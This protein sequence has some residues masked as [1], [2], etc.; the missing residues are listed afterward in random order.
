MRRKRARQSILI[1]SRSSVQSRPNPR[2]KRERERESLGTQPNKKN[3]TSSHEFYF[4]TLWA[5]E[6]ATFCA[7]IK[8]KKISTEFL[9]NKTHRIASA[10]VS[11]SFSFFFLSFLLFPHEHHHSANAEMPAATNEFSI[12]FFSVQSRILYPPNCTLKSVQIKLLFRQFK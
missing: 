1:A 5:T 12:F 11:L 10:R 2:T 8:H 9:I 4:Q 3:N 7:K 6:P